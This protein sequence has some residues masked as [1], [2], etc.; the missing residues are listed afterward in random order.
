VTTAHPQDQ[1]PRLPCPQCG[2]HFDLPGRLAGHLLEQ[3]GTPKD[4]A[5]SEA[6]RILRD[7]LIRQIRQRH[8]LNQAARAKREEDRGRRSAAGKLGLAATGRRS[9][10][11]EVAQRAWRTQIRQRTPRRD[12]VLLT[13]IEGF[14]GGLEQDGY[15]LP[16]TTQQAIDAILVEG[17]ERHD[18]ISILCAYVIDLFTARNVPD[19]DAELLSLEELDRRRS[20]RRPWKD[21]LDAALPNFAVTSLGRPADGFYASPDFVRE[22]HAEHE[23][24]LTIVRDAR[25]SGKPSAFDLLE[26]TS[27]VAAKMPS[28]WRSRDSFAATGLSTG[29]RT[30][31]SLG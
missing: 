25:G 1:P 11:M 4:R 19:Q 17:R 20:S 13:S 6:A 30:T 10:R 15:E 31:D 5:I 14:V 26:W 22:Q 3:H 12:E 24:V 16:G 8:R 2:Q 23:T 18:A 29:L 28:D 9:K 27:G 21:S 7:Q